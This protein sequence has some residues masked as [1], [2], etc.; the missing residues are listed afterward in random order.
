MDNLKGISSNR[1][2][3]TPISSSQ[4][5]NDR[6]RGKQIDLFSFSLSDRTSLSLKGRSSETGTTIRLAQDRNQ[7]G[8][9]DRGEVLKSFASRANKVAST[10]FPE[11]TAG[12]YLI[13]VTAIQQGNSRYRLSL[14]ADNAQLTVDQSES[15]TTISAFSRQV[16][17][18]TNAFRKQNN[19]APLTLNSKL[20]TVAQTYSKTMATQD[21]LAHEGLDGSQ[22]WDRMTAGGYNWSRAAENV[23]AGQ[24]TPE[25]VMQ[26]WIS[27]AGH[28]ANLLD[29]QLKEIGVGY[30]FLAN[31]TGSVNYNHYWTQNFGAPA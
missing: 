15:A 24:T 27:S 5:L 10:K 31:D 23:A 29:P 2:Q 25:E 20:T 26:S 16:V 17:D 30:F 3:A 18:L 6:V 14:A 7:N 4:T 12:K 28:R 13:Q 1:V 22:P 11:L 8:A 21:F 9:I 19:L